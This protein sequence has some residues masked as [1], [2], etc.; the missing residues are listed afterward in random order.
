MLKR[1][2]HLVAN[3]YQAFGEMLIV[4]SQ[5]ADRDEEVINVVEHNG[6]FVGV[7][8]L[9]GKECNWMVPPMTKWV[10]VMRGVI[11]IVVA[12]SVTLSDC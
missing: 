4:L 2:V 12:V 11:T 5:Q 8:L 9:L 3:R 10:E 6:V 7:L 1:K